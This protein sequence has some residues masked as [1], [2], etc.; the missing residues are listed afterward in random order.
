MRNI[1]IDG[2][3][4][5]LLAS[6]KLL[7]KPVYAELSDGSRRRVPDRQA[8]D[9][10]TQVPLWIIDCFLDDGE[11]EGRAEVVAVT[12]PCIEK[13]VVQKFKPLEFDG[14]EARAYVRDGRVGLSFSADALVSASVRAA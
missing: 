14:L 5:T 3:R 8:V 6:G 12:V 9:Q 7:P 4:I 1:P 11:E 13:P 2:T 10:E